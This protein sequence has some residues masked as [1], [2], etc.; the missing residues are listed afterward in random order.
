MKLIYVAGP[1]RAPSGIERLQNITRAAEY[2]RKLWT[3][4][5][6]AIC[7]HLN[8]IEMDGPGLTVEQI[9]E[10]D[11]E[12]VRRCDELHVLPNWSSSTGTCA[13]IATARDAG[14]RI[15]FLEDEKEPK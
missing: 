9:L 3:L 12:I 7:P 13:E 4:G 8:T 1:Y 14:L 10:G 15:V 6:A 11:L 5:H 2:A